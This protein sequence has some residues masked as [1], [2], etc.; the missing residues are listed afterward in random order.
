MS[1]DALSANHRQMLVSESGIRPEIVEARGYR[2][3]TTKADLKRLGFSDRQQNAPALLIPIYN[4]RGELA[5]YQ[6]RADSP[7]IVKGKPAKYETPKGSSMVLDVH[8]AARVKLGDPKTPLFVTEG[9]KKGDALVSHGLTAVA[10][11]GVWNW[12]G[13]NEQGGKT[14]LA[15]WEHIAL[16]NRR[17]YIVFDSDVMLKPSVHSALVRLKAFLEHRHARVALIYLP[18]G[19]G[20]SKQ[21]V[22]DYLA[23]GHTVSD[24]VKLA[25][26]ETLEL[27]AEAEQDSEKTQAQRLIA[28]AEDHLSSLFHSPEQSAYALAPVKDHD[29]VMDVRAKPFR[30]LLYRLYYNESGKPPGSQ[31]VQDALSVLEAKALYEGEERP[32]YVRLAEH[33]GKVYLD[34]CD[35]AWRVVEIDASGWRV[36]GR[37]PVAFRR[38][39][40]MQALP[41]PVAGG[42][43]AELRAF[44]N[45]DDDAWALIAGFMAACLRPGIPYPLLIL[46]AEQGSGKSTAAEFLKALLD[47]SHAPLRSEPRE[48]RDL[49]ISANNSWLLAYDNLSNVPLWLSD[50]LCRLST[51]GGFSTRTLYANDEETI[52][53]AMRPVILTGIDELAS[54][55][56]LLDRALV[57]ELQPIPRQDRKQKRD[58]E[59]HFAAAAPGILGALLTAV[60]HGLRNEARVSP[61]DLP[62]MADFA[63]WVLACENA[64][65]LE[66]GHFIRAYR[67]NR[68]G[69]NEMA[70]D[71][72]PLPALLWKLGAWEGTASELQAELD[73][74]ASEGVKRLRAYPKS[75]K[76]LGS[77]LRRLAPNL[78]ATGLEVHFYKETTGQKRRLIRISPQANVTNDTVDT[79][80]EQNRPARESGGGASGDVRADDT[81]N[82][83]ANVTV[84][85]PPQTEKPTSGVN[86]DD[87]YVKE[88]PRSKEDAVLPTPVAKPE[89]RPVASALTW[90]EF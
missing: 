45:A 31:A 64:L 36:C 82:V 85:A 6:A 67:E 71:V 3:V 72:S 25:S 23:A 46:I 90:E 21:G 78:R 56:D 8:P 83:T 27:R 50:A 76:A 24:L 19:E 38:P 18:P 41:V 37:S 2:T 70:L 84:E 16:N 68:S 22:D 59:R 14:A 35:D 81:G 32:V 39:K 49:M 55:G 52:F 87:G 1:E 61:P 33:G 15:D 51:G 80:S 43:L 54:R 53:S 34:L 7:R 77:A 11:I 60:S 89:T 86:G 65:R 5:T 4:P 48:A 73:A 12:R 69:A 57:V 44:V 40:G 17:V 13:A 42:E 26:S 79:G 66:P 47:A 9:I 20:A 28:L 10:L 58:L 74:R 75:A 88:P 62:R 30:S 29:E 63:A